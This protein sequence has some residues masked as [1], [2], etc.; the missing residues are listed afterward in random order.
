MSLDDIR[1]RN[2]LQSDKLTDRENVAINDNYYL[3]TVYMRRKRLMDSEWRSD[4]HLPYVN[5]V[6]K[7]FRNEELQKYSIKTIIW[8]TL[9]SY[10]W[11]YYRAANRLK[12]KPA[13]GV[14]SY[15]SIEEY[16]LYFDRILDDMENI[17]TTFEKQVIS[18]LMAEEI[19]SIIVGE[20]TRRIVK[21]L[22]M[23]YKKVEI[24]RKLDSSY[25]EINKKIYEARKDVSKLYR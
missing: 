3:L 8:R 9:D 20:R 2:G 22:M 6:R 18:K 24:I 10:R 13:G 25:Y 12:R 16:I 15:D 11:N 19:L 23:G 1:R 5:G 21:M 7:Y 17:Y 14:C 4:L